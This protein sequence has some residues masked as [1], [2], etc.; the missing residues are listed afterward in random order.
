MGPSIP[1]RDCTHLPAVAAVQRGHDLRVNMDDSPFY[2]V[3]WRQTDSSQL[4]SKQA[5]ES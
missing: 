2:L 3:C 4:H 5:N 1:V